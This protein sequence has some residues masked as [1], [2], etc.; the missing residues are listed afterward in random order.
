LRPALASDE[1]RAV[2]HVRVHQPHELS[3]ESAEADDRPARTERVLED[4]AVLLMS[5]TTL[6]TAWSGYQKETSIVGSIDPPCGEAGA[7]T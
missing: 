2:G 6:A 4:V 7:P 3:D 5:V 1:S